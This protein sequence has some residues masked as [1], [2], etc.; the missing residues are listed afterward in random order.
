MLY[1]WPL[2]DLKKKKSGR[3]TPDVRVGGFEGVH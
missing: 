1:I 3:V 2:I